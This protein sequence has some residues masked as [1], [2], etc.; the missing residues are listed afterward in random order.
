MRLRLTSGW[1]ESEGVDSTNLMRAFLANLGC[2]NVFAN[3]QK[4]LVND[5]LRVLLG[6][7]QPTGCTHELSEQGKESGHC[8]GV[9]FRSPRKCWEE[10]TASAAECGT[11]PFEVHAATSIAGVLGTPRLHRGCRAPHRADATGFAGSV[12]A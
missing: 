7:A 12:P 11:G 10:Y 9:T 2:P 6:A 8:V 4:R 5:V 3:S 1:V